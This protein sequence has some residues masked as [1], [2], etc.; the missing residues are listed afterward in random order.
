MNRLLGRSSSLAKS[1]AILV[2]DSGMWLVSAS[3]ASLLRFEFRAQDVDWPSTLLFASL[4]ALA[5]IAFGTLNHLYRRRYIV[6]SVDELKALFGVTFLVAIVASAASFVW[7]EQLGIPR[8]IGLISGAFFLIL[9]GAVR[10]GIRLGNVRLRAQKANPDR[11]IIFGAGEAAESLIPQLLSDPDSPYTPVAL[12]DDAPEKSN[13]WIRGVPMAGGFTGLVAAVEKYHAN[14]LIVAIPSAGGELLQSVYR[15]SRACGLEVVVLPPLA[16]YLAGNS[17]ISSLKKLSVEDLLGRQIVSLPSESVSGLIRG[18]R[19]LITGAGGSIGSELAKQI[20]QFGPSRLVLADRDETFLLEILNQLQRQSTEPEFVTHLVEIRDQQSVQQLF[21]LEEPQV[22]FHTAA[23]KHL[24]ML[25]R[26]PNEAWKTN[27]EG[28]LHLLEAAKKVEG[29]T[30]VNVSTDKAANPQSILGRSKLVAERLTAWFAQETQGTFVS[31][32]FGNVFRSR[33]SLIPI[34]EDQ[35]L[36]GGPVTI[37]DRDAT[38]YFMA[39]SEACQLVL[40][41]ASE[42]Q[43]GEVLVLDMGK[44][45]RIQDIA[46]RL[47]EFSGRNVDIS[48]IGLRPGE[49]LHE[50]LFSNAESLA[51]SSHPKIFRFHSEVINPDT[52]VNLKW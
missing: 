9:T 8:S 1:V 38:R 29:V 16:E 12:L 51:P 34:L 19:V 42:A 50:D 41:A 10:L 37:T 52:L 40:A 31:V 22:V 35:I 25:E 39:V 44:P 47:I 20:A 13:R 46:E 48:Y 7:V 18:K 11:A 33:G 24:S 4:M 23:L 21:E 15:A 45:V 2:I 49:K 30:F 5:G 27:V 17:S 14:V 36:S 32:R 26:F 3:V 28:T 43:G 6:G